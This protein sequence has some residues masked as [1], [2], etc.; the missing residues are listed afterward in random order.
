MNSK[1]SGSEVLRSCC[2]VNGDVDGADNCDFYW[3]GGWGVYTSRMGYMGESSIG[4]VACIMM[5]LCVA[6]SG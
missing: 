4:E 2:C 6:T 3:H 1:K 5:L